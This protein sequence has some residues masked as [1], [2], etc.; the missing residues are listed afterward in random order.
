M[1]ISLLGQPLHFA[2]SGKVAP[3]RALKS[4]MTE[5]LCTYDQDN[6][7]ERGKPTSEYGRL[8]EEWGKG[9]LGV[10]VSGNI[11]VDRKGL[12]AKGNAVID[13]RSESAWDPVEAFKPVISAAKAEG[14]L[15]LAQLTHGGRQTSEEIDPFPV[16]AGD[17][18]CPPSFGMTFAKPRPMT[19]KE[20]DELVVGFGYA[21]RKW[22][23]AGGDGIQLHA[24]HGYLL[25][26]FLAANINTR[27]DEY[28]GSL[29]NRARILF[30]ILDEVKRQVPQDFLLAVKINSA[31]FSS[32]GLTLEESAQV[33]EWLD[34]AGVELLELS[35][36]TYE[37]GL[38]LENKRES[39]KKREAYFV[40]FAESIKPRIKNAH[41]CVTGGFRSRDGMEEALHTNACELVGLA[42]PLTAEPH[43]IR[44]ILDGKTEG[45]KEN[46]VPAPQQIPT[47]LVQIAAVAAGRSIP[48]L[49]NEDVAKATVAEATQKK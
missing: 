3:T 27:T 31:D 18:Q 47:A 11:P 16:S 39:T 37:A 46:K 33:C 30:R 8:Y 17:V 41:I 6:L 35:G 1:S 19:L 21:A 34:Q 32:G 44:D 4:A 48:D 12:E 24:A 25:S 13:P 26:Q 20:I 22:Y 7:E 36:G 5:R 9:R 10:I 15:F 45:A 28:G 42:R 38:Q 23:D 43:L 14:S 49:S 40:E 29:E 2:R